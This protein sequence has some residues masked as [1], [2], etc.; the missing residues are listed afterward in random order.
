MFT[1]PFGLKPDCEPP[2]DPKC[3]EGKILTV[4]ANASVSAA[5]LFRDLGSL[6]ARGFP[7]GG[8]LEVGIAVN[9]NNGASAAFIRGG[10]SVGVGASGGLEVSLQKGTLAD[11]LGTGAIEIEHDRGMGGL[12]AVIDAQGRFRGGGA[13]AGFGLY[14]G[15]NFTNFSASVSITTSPR[16]FQRCMGAAV[17]LAPICS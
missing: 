4:S 14:S 6:R 7:V 17:G 8:N 12:N 15:L 16:E 11:A 13:N 1:D 3:Q 5:R 10:G 2:D 9:L